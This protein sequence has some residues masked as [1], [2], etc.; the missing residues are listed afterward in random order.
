MG[1]YSVGSFKQTEIGRTL[2]VWWKYH[3]L[4]NDNTTGSSPC[5][6]HQ[7]GRDATC[8]LTLILPWNSVST[9]QSNSLTHCAD[10][11]G[12]IF[13]CLFVPHRSTIHPL[14]WSLGPLGNRR[15][16]I[17]ITSTLTR[18][19]STRGHVDVLLRRQVKT[20]CEVYT[21]VRAARE[22]VWGYACCYEPGTQG[23]TAAIA[24]YLHSFIMDMI[25][26]TRTLPGTRRNLV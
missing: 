17:V 24:A 12:T 1:A 3:W 4:D 26:E 10:F 14:H 19:F 2:I 22:R 15:I 23:I 11:Q 9:N 6:A 20:A 18:I 5:S 16:S 8:Q 7:K 25:S 21:P 13:S